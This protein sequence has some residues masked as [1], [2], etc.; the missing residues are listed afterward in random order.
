MLRQIENDLGVPLFNRTVSPFCLTYAGEKYLQAADIILAANQRL[1]NELQEIKQENSGRLR[2]GISVQRATQVLPL[3]L[4][5]FAR[6]Y[7]NVSIELTEKGSAH[8]EEMV[9][10]GQ[11]DLAFAAI[12]STSP[13]LAYELIEMEIIGVLAGKASPL[14]NVV[15]SGTP[16][17]PEVAQDETFINLKVGHSIRVVQDKLFRR[18]GLHPHILLE[19]DSLEVAKRVALESGACMLCSNIYVDQMVKQRGAFYPLKD[20]ENH[21]HFY[22]CYRKGE[23]LPRYTSEFIRIVTHTLAENRQTTQPVFPQPSGVR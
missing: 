5:Q 7:P 9:H 19:T 15:P 12:E 16:I 21:R 22:A 6:Q 10:Q 13:H 2:L 3:A 4:P 11:I 18:Y 14:A 8:L 1:E 17:T 20:Y 23:R